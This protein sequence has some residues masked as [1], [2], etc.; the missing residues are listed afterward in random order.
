MTVQFLDWNFQTRVKRK[1]IVLDFYI[2]FDCR[3]NNV[4]ILSSKH[5]HNRVF[6][7]E[8]PQTERGR[9]GRE[10]GRE[11]GREGGGS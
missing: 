9:G 3:A 4:K 6:S 7:E 8:Q 1:K 11:G 10:E 2:N 5:T